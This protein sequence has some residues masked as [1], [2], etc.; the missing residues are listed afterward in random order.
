MVYALLGA[1]E[2]VVE[3]AGWALSTGS[4]DASLESRIQAVLAHGTCYARGP[5]A[6]LA[7]LPRLDADLARVEL[8]QVESLAF[9][10]IFR[11]LAGNLAQAVDDLSA[12][13][14]LARRGA[15][16][17]QGM[18][19]YFYCAL[20]QYLAG[21]WDDALLSAEHGASAASIHP[22]R[23]ELPLLHLAAV[24][25]PAGRGATEE[26]EMHA[27]LAEEAAE[28]LDYGEERLYA[29]MARAF[30]CQARGDYAGVVAALDRWHF[31]RTLDT[32]SRTHGL[33]WRPLLVEG[34]I[35]SGR[36]EEAEVV[37]G[38]LHEDADGVS[39]LQPAL[40]WLDGWLAERR[41][42]PD[43]AL[44]IYARAQETANID[45]PVY[46][47]RLQLAHGRLLRL[48]GQRREAIEHLRRASDTYLAL[49]AAPL[50]ARTEEELAGCGLPQTRVRR[51]SMLEM[52]SRES[53]VARLVA[54]RMTNNEIATE[55]FVTNKAVEYHLGNIYAK[56]GVHSRGQLRHLLDARGMRAPI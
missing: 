12:S 38:I 19:A 44:D 46:V 28:S 36:H 35:G 50:V 45:S 56:F 49:R 41:G 10:G 15:T 37:L 34:L 39:Y 52:T 6:A 42:A 30:L 16:F 7:E 47:A 8:S 24:C 31:D 21:A 26:A 11:L 33:L 18:R 51:Q 13:L 40:A 5:K 29:G 25:V 27:K 3:L 1:G 53:E 9:R 43:A 32:R 4:L 17:S 23:Y 48:T 14:R 20:A 55:L 2:K 22:R 54:Q